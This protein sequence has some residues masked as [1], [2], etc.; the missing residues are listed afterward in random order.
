M[1]G[2]SLSLSLF[3]FFGGKKITRRAREPTVPTAPKSK[4]WTTRRRS[5]V[6]GKAAAGDRLNLAGEMRDSSLRA[7]RE[8][9][10]E[11]GGLGRGWRKYRR[12]EKNQIKL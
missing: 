1:K 4:Q 2:T 3:L 5:G 11:G 12:Q 9:N 6:V 7:G 10:R 8:E